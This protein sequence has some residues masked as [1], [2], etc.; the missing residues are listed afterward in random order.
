MRLIE[1]SADL[2]ASALKVDNL[3][4]GTLGTLQAVLIFINRS[5]GRVQGGEGQKLL[6]EQYARRVNA[7]LRDVLA[8]SDLP[9]VLASN[10]PLASIYRSVNSYPHLAR[11]TL[12]GGSDR[13]T[14]AEFAASARPML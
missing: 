11:E 6:L 13:L 2:P 5:M 1:V 14:D 12:Y 4:E 7:A 3:P 10:E 8:G 9:L